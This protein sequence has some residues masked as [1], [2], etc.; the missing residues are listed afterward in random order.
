MNFGVPRVHPA[1]QF[2]GL[3]FA[4]EVPQAHALGVQ[5]DVGRARHPVALD[6]FLARGG[7]A[8][9]NTPSEASAVV[10]IAAPGGL[11]FGLPPGLPLGNWVS[12]SG[13]RPVRKYSTPRT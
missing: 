9:S 1:Q 6:G 3:V 2:E 13:H 5:R 4:A 11:Q 10:A 8:S 7:K 12:T